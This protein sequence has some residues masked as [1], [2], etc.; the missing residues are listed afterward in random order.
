M[1]DPVYD[2]SPISS[3]L[4]CSVDTSSNSLCSL[5][6]RLVQHIFSTKVSD[7]MSTKLARSLRN[8]FS[9][10]HLPI[11]SISLPLLKARTY[12]VT[13][14]HERLGSFFPDNCL[15]VASITR[16]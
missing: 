7:T 5:L 16:I 13:K 1:T 9:P 10:F 3:T 8:W 12:F 15:F 2:C 4:I 14:Q 6:S 11:I